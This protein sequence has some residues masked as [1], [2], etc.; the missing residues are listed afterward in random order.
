MAPRHS[1]R[2]EGS[3]GRLGD[4]YDHGI[5]VDGIGASHLVRIRRNSLRPS[6]PQVR[7]NN[8][9]QDQ[10]SGIRFG[11]S[12]V[13][14]GLRTYVQSVRCGQERGGKL[15]RSGRGGRIGD[16][17]VR[18]RDGYDGFVEESRRMERSVQP[19]T[20]GGF[21]GRS[22]RERGN[23]EECKCVGGG[24]RCHGRG[25]CRG[26]DG[27]RAKEWRRIILGGIAPSDIHGGSHRTDTARLRRPPAY[28]DRQRRRRRR[29]QQQ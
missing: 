24:G 26:G 7:R 12:H 2:R 23:G 3:V 20:Y 29:R 21:D 10:H 28:H 14:S 8:Y 4:T 27:G 18:G 11:V 19:E 13:Q 9:R 15:G 25:G 16:G 17:I 22:G 5:D 1:S 6:T